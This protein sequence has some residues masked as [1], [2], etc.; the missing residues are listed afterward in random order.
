MATQT[1]LQ[2][3]DATNPEIP[4]EKATSAG[5]EENERK[6]ELGHAEIAGTA[7]DGDKVVLPNQYLR[8]LCP[9]WA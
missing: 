1:N 6:E 9:D 4:V 3:R 8:H 2:P 5:V 7:G